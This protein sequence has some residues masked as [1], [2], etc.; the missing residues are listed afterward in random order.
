MKKFGVITLAVV[1]VVFAGLVVKGLFF[2]PS[3]E[4]LIR[5]TLAQAT[6]AAAKGEPNEVLDALSRNF[7]YGEES[8]IRMD[9]SK[10]VRE[11]RPEMVILN[12]TPKIDGERAVVVSDVS[13]KVD[14]LGMPQ[15]LTVEGV[16]IELQKETTFQNLIPSPKWRVTKV[17]AEALPQGY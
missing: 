15:D 9:I 13:L 5:Q 16:T 6:E 14:F 12:T 11:A 3:D 7:Q 17:T 1:L 10:V 2:G 8:P 4:V